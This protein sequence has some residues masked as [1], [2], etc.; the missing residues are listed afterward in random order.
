MVLIRVHHQVNIAFDKMCMC[1]V[2]TFHM[3][4]CIFSYKNLTAYPDQWVNLFDK[5]CALKI[6]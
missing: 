1:N 6:V 5:Q 3:L 4:F 2:E